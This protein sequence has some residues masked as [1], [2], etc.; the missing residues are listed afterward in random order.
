MA[1]TSGTNSV[2]T[3]ATMIDGNSVMPLRLLIHNNDNTDAVFLGGSA[4]TTSTGFKLDKGIVLEL[5]LNPLEELYA[6]S[7]KSGHVI[8]WI[9]QAI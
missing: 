9:R 8:S 6:V 4:V 1:L 2:G 5:I 3:T 7:T